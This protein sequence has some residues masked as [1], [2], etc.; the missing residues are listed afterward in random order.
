MSDCSH[1]ALVSPPSLAVLP[2]TVRLPHITRLSTVAAQGVFVVDKPEPLDDNVTVG[3]H[4][5]RLLCETV[6]ETECVWDDVMA[7]GVGSREAE[8]SSDC[9]DVSAD[10]VSSCEADALC[11]E[12]EDDVKVSLGECEVESVDSRV[13]DVECVNTIEFDG[14]V[15]FANCGPKKNA[16]AAVQ[17]HFGTWLA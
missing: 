16:S 15:Q 12:G 11:S 3:N 8:L 1:V 6:G 14:V 9:D 13:N 5:E 7:D 10:G 2:N 4:N 17:N